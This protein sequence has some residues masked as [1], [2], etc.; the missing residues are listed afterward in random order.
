MNHLDYMSDLKKAWARCR[1]QSLKR[2]ASVVKFIN[3]DS[4][5]PIWKNDIHTGDPLDVAVTN[6]YCKAASDLPK[7]KL[8]S[9]PIDILVATT[10]AISN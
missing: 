5:L 7:L 8:D 10:F 3:E 9:T 2:I 4:R 1:G 6:P